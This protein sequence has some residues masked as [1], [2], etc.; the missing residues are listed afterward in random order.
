MPSLS[1]YTKARASLIVKRNISQRPTVC[2]YTKVTVHLS[3]HVC[4]CICVCV[5]EREREK[6]LVTYSVLLVRIANFP[7]GY[8]P[9]HMSGAL[10]QDSMIPEEIIL[11]SILNQETQNTIISGEWAWLRMES[12]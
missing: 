6:D 10:L 8:E 5:R 9:S 3:V 7:Q 11:S 2:R 12:G 1:H 4:A